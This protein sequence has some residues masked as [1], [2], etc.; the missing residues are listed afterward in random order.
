MRKA[1]YLFLCS[2]FAASLDASA[3][4]SLKDGKGEI[5]KGCAVEV[6]SR[7]GNVREL[8]IDRT[9]D[10]KP[11][12]ASFLFDKKTGLPASGP[13]LCNSYD[14]D[15]KPDITIDIFGDF[16]KYNYSCG[17]TFDAY[18][19]T[20]ELVVNNKTGKIEYVFIN[21]K[22]AYGPFTVGSYV[23]L[24][25]SGPIKQTLENFSCASEVY[26][27]DVQAVMAAVKVQSAIASI[28][29]PGRGGLVNSEK[30][31]V[32]RGR[33]Q[34]SAV[35]VDGSESDTGGGGMRTAR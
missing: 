25:H 2:L 19:T 34:K 33:Y 14:H 6:S 35:A 11:M 8:R 24:S 13:N 31:V 23:V 1:F 32:Y 28:N 20:A 29:N 3:T 9:V 17:G 4:P 22:G 30:G 12:Y 18:D 15:L 21:F 5:E 16:V 10:G 26:K 27:R 7:A